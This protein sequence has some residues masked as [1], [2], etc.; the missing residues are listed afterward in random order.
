MTVMMTVTSKRQVTFPKKLLEAIGAKA[1]DRL[2]ARMDNGRLII[3][4]KGRGIL[5]LIGK[6]PSIKIPKGK[7]VD[8]M[9]HEAA[10]YYA[11]RD[12]R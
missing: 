3:E 5:D 7:T 9:I 12:V 1:G 2:A 10:V 8:D 4:P 11:G 6:L